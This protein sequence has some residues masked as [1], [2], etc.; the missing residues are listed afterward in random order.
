MLIN[1]RV[2]GNILLETKIPGKIIGL[3]LSGK[4]RLLHGE[5]QKLANKAY[6]M[7]FPVAVLMNATL[8]GLEPDLL[9]MTDNRL[10]F[11]VKLYWRALAV[12]G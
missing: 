4:V 7:R 3:Q 11:G 10:G 5:D 2:A 6:L 9:K 1:P 8:W 12:T